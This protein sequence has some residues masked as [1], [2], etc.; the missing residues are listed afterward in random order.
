LWITLVLFRRVRKSPP[1]TYSCVQVRIWGVTAKNSAYH[2][3]VDALVVLERIEKLNKP[4]A[5][6]RREDIALRQNVTHFV[7]L[8]EEPLAHY[9]ERDHLSR[10]LLLRQVNLSVSTLAHLRQDLEIALPQSCSPLPQV[11]PLAAQVLVPGLLVLFRLHG[12]RRRIL[13][14]ELSE[15]CLSVVH[16]AQQAVI[17]VEKVYR[18]H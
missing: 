4:L 5:V 1:G 3:K 6:R 10:I 18:K 15:A 12:R 7:E 9:L 8:E 16:I 13:R 2:S 17:V 11:R 14:V